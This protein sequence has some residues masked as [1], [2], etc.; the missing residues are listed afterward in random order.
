MT[1][2][3]EPAANAVEG[4]GTEDRREEV[5]VLPDRLLLVTG[6]GLAERREE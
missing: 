3:G 4:W 6:P 5:G 1:A 2:A